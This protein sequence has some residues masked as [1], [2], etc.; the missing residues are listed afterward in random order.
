MTPPQTWGP[1]VWTMFH[2]LCEKINENAYPRV[3]QQMFAHFVRICK[4]LPCPDCAADASRFLAKISFKNLQTKTD[5]KNT[6]YLFHNRVNAKKRKQLFNYA[7]MPNYQKYKITD[8]LNRFLSCYQTTGN[9]NL[10][11]ESF[12]RK[13]IIKDFKNWFAG[14]YI[15]FLPAPK[16]SNR[17]IT[18]TIT[19]TNDEP[20]NVESADNLCGDFGGVTIMQSDDDF[21]G[22]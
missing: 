3:G 4:F 8:V 7:N 1:A 21:V 9:M 15:A 12:Q 10:I 6:F 22:E 18:N 20:K 14:A 16:P 5:L 17:T 2:V 11:A 13:L 19:N